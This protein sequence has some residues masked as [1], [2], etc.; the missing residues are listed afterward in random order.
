MEIFNDI[1]TTTINSFDIAYCIVVNVLTYILINIINSHTKTSISTW[2][3]RLVLLLSIILVGSFYIITGIDIKLIINS[4][5]LAPV[6]WS[7]IMKPVCKFFNIDYK[8]LSLFD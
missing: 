8:Q 5:I 3:K 6:F 1:I 7:W 2:K 4:S